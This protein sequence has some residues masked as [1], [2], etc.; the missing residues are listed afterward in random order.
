MNKGVSR[1]GVTNIA[2]AYNDLF[3]TGLSHYTTRLLFD[4]MVRLLII[5]FNEDNKE[6][7]RERFMAVVYKE[8]K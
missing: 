6:F 7:D 5:M 1:S 3:N 8:N 2:R 4:E